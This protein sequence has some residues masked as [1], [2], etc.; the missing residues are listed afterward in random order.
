MSVLVKGGWNAGNT[1]ACEEVV[2]LWARRDR[3]KD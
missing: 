1:V 3:F 2:G